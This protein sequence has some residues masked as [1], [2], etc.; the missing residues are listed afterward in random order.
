MVFGERAATA[1]EDGWLMFFTM[2]REQTLFPTF[3][4]GSYTFVI[5]FLIDEHEWKLWTLRG[6]LLS[7]FYNPAEAQ[8]DKM[9]RA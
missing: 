1:A 7:M 6:H 3:F 9:M 4:E 8:V 2:S 5:M